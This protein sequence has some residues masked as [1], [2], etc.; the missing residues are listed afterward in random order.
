MIKIK[1][2]KNGELLDSLN[3]DKSFSLF[4]LRIALEGII[5]EADWCFMDGDEKI[6]VKHE[7]R[8]TSEDILEKTTS[9]V[10]IKTF[11]KTTETEIW[12]DN[13]R[14]IRLDLNLT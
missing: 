12:K 11:I 2:I 6:A 3:V 7:N 1:I 4:E 10:F 13:V 14:V 9:Q 5:V 8:F